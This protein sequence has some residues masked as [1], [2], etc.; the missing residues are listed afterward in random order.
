MTM[1]SRRLF[2]GAAACGCLAALPAFA[3]DPAAPSPTGQYVCP[4]CGCSEDGKVFDKPGV[5][6][7]DGC[8]MTLIPK[9]AP[10]P[11][12]PQGA[13]LPSGG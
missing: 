11:T 6:P 2:V 9:P 3:Q 5:C 4:P 13:G 12:A 10:A 7:A 1:L 8:G